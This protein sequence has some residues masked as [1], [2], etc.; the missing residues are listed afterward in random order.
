MAR[1]S[2]RQRVYN[3]E[4]DLRVE[5]HRDRQYLSTMPELQEWVD[6]VVSSRWFQ[7][8]WPVSEVIVKDGRG[9]RKAYGDAYLRYGQWT[10]E[11]CMPRWSRYKLIILHELAH[12][13]TVVQYPYADIAAHGR[14][15]CS[16][17]LQLV[18][19]WIGNDVKHELK[20]C[21]KDNRVKYTKRSK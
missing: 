2:Q 6:D 18:G 14:E 11:I 9:R 8:R 20:K 16:N 7:N 10:G 15:F 13:A 5:Y 12:T 17:F 19:R 21:M 3:A 1:D 4:I